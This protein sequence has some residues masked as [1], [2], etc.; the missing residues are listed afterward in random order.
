M[1]MVEYEYSFKVKDIQPFIAYCGEKGYIKE[2]DMCIRKI[3]LH[4]K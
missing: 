1:K 4:L 3:M 2:K